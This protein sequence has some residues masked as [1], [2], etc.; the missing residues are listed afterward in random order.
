MR[1]LI[2][3][4]SILS[5]AMNMNSQDS[6]KN[7]K[8]DTIQQNKENEPKFVVVDE[9]ALFQGGNI[10]KFKDWV[11]K[12]IIFPVEAAKKTNQRELIVQFSVNS[13]GDIEDAIALHKL[14]PDIEKEAFRCIN[15]SP[16]WTPAKKEGKAVK[17]QF[18]MK[19]VLEEKK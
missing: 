12:S 14:N 1:R 2:L 18:V 17:Q 16:G 8:T 13:K 4:S 6:I 9:N 5:I 3:I 11:E 15:N 10:N 7:I 19:I